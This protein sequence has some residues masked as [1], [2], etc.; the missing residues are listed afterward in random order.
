MEKKDILQAFKQAE[1]DWNESIDKRYDNNTCFGLCYYF[2]S[3]YCT[4]KPFKK[5]WIKHSIKPKDFYHFE[6][7]GKYEQGRQERLKAIRKVIKE[8]EK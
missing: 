7:F 8:L 2:T 5:Y 6:S 4:M 3:K 1:I